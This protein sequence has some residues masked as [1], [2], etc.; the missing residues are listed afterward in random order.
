MVVDAAAAPST[1]CTATTC[2]ATTAEEWWAELL[3]F[4]PAAELRCA[5]KAAGAAL[6]L[7]AD[8]SLARELLRGLHHEHV[9]L[10]SVHGATPQAGLAI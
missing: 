8:F 4:H 6:R 7:P 3:R 9:P 10:S 5:A 1:A 2:A